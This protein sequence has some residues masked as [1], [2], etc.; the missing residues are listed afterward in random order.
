LNLSAAQQQ[1]LVNLDQFF[2]PSAFID[3]ATVLSAIDQHVAAKAAAQ[4]MPA[5]VEVAP[6]SADLGFEPAGFGCAH[7]DPAWA[8]GF[9]SALLAAAPL[10]DA[11]QLAAWRAQDHSLPAAG[12][13]NPLGIDFPSPTAASNPTSPQGSAKAAWAEA[14]SRLI[15]QLGMNGPPSNVTPQMQEILSAYATTSRGALNGAASSDAARPPVANVAARR[16]ARNAQRAEVMAKPL[17]IKPDALPPPVSGSF[18]GVTEFL[19][20]LF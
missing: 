19:R 9:A 16:A 13:D 14:A 2:L 5:E 10:L 1:T 4:A 15:P 18:F 11:E 20:S 12:T 8:D 6:L 7:D 3:D 17:R